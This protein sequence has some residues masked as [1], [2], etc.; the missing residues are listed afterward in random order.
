ME[1]K[2]CENGRIIAESHNIEKNNR[3]SL[4]DLK[5]R[6]GLLR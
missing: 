2:T 5:N 3:G 6:L 1:E 4:P